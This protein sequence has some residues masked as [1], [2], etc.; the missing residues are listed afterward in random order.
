MYHRKFVTVN[1][2]DAGNLYNSNKVNE[3]LYIL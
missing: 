3:I 2:E 1:D